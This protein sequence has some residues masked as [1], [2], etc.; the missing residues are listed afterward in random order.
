ML[1]LSARRSVQPLPIAIEPSDADA[2]FEMSLDNVCVAGLDGY[3]R[4]VNPAWTQTLGWSQAELLARPV[5][6]FVHPDDREATLAGRQ[7]LARGAELGPLCNRY[8]CKDG[9]YRWFE[10]RSVAHLARGLV[11][12]VARDITDQKHA[13]EQL[14]QA[15]QREA[16]LQKQLVFADRMASVGTLAAGLAHEINNPLAYVVANSSLLLDSLRMLESHIP[17]PHLL[18]LR[19]MA[20]SVQE[21]AERIRKIM[22]GLKTFSRVEREQRVVLELRP[23]LEL[24]ID[25]AF[26]E[27]RHRARLVKDYGQ[28]PA[29]DAD[30]TRLGQVF[31]N[32]L[33]N[34]AHAMPEGHTDANEIRITT[35]TSAAG[36]ALIE[37]R[38]TGCGIPA[39]ILDRIFDPF[40]TTKPVGVG[41]G[42]GLAICHDIIT[43][44]GGTI[45]VEST[46]GVGTVFRIELP[47]AARAPVVAPPPT[48][49]KK[50]LVRVRVLVL[51]DEP[52]IANVLGRILCD[53][54]V[55]LLTSPREALR[56]VGSGKTFD[57]IFSDLMMP[58]M[59][60][61]D[62][63]AELTRDSP[64]LASRVV[65]VS[66]GAFTPGAASFLE[67]S[68]NPRIEKPFDPRTV[69]E[70]VR[71]F[72]PGT[73]GVLTGPSGVD[74]RIR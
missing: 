21:G 33:V 5:I 69:L 43:G 48:R 16:T 44:L 45:R 26:N 39:S 60:G 20:L 35:S 10:W 31:I 34:A 63:Y 73:E 1:G 54:D 17:S 53:H 23:L 14:A 2:L 66:G 11:Y 62:F 50:P 18:E 29:V 36:T 59:S 4:R 56:L 74:Q 67:H 15:R 25:M 47:A 6:D 46:E 64:Q 61:M 40:F 55:T 68:V 52:E 65:F 58:E 41:T 19:D 72:T 8:L 38:D 13:E 30:E 51:D 27:I 49:P 7:R 42:L 3:F 57:V 28:T 22:R 12:A 9:T 70:L 24:S 32:L 71:R 37:V